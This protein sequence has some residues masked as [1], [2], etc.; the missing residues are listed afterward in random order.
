MAKEGFSPTTMEKT[1]FLLEKPRA[2]IR[3]EKKQGVE[4][5]GNKKGNGAI[6]RH[7]QCFVNT[8]WPHAFLVKMALH[9]ILRHTGDPKEEV[10]FNP[11]DADSR[12]QSRRHVCTACHPP[13]PVALPQLKVPKSSIYKLDIHIRIQFFLGRYFSI[14]MRIP[15]M[16]PILIQIC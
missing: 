9:R 4:I 12:L 13:Q 2:E 16:I 8:I 7:C 3:E 11:T 14:I 15:S 1:K 10:N 6:Q 5:P